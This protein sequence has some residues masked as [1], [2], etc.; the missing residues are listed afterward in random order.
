[1]SCNLLL[2]FGFGGVRKL[3]LSSNCEAPQQ[4]T[5]VVGLADAAVVGRGTPWS[6]GSLKLGSKEGTRSRFLNFS[7][8]AVGK[9]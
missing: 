7:G 5:P 6:S 1:M 3:R 9:K 8:R 4:A 2:F